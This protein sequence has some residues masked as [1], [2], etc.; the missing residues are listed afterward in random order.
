MVAAVDVCVGVDAAQGVEVVEEWE[1]EFYVGF[2]SLSNCIVEAWDAVY[3]VQVEELSA[4]V[5][6]LVVD[7]FGFG[8]CVVG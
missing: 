2:F 6:N 5:E 1:D 4:G 8:R 3:G 7:C